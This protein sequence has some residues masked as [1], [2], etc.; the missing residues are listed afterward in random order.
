MAEGLKVLL[1]EDDPAVRFGAVQALS[2]AGLE[3]EAFESAEA[4]RSQLHPFFPGV[5]VTD[6]KLRGMS[7]LDLLDE[8]RAVDVTLPVILVTGHGDIAMAVQAMKAGAYDFIEKPF[9]ADQLVGSV[10]RALEKR[11]LSLEVQELRHQLADR[12]GIESVLL[13]SS[14]GMVELRQTILNDF[15][16]L[17]TRLQV[18]APFLKFHC[19]GQILLDIGQQTAVIEI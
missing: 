17:Q 10:L 7:G 9:A 2:L 11:G 8:A 19:L 6:I 3:V 12:R 1:V 4:A 5:L 15:Q 18:D 13:G 16:G 14:P